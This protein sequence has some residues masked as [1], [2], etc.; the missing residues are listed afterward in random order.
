MLNQ[1]GMEPGVLE[2]WLQ[3]QTMTN[4]ELVLLIKRRLVVSFVFVID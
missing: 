2:K 3:L 4:V 1:P